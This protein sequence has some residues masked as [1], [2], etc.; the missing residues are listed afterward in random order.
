MPVN[1]LY[2]LHLHVDCEKNTK[3]ND[4]DRLFDRAQ[5]IPSQLE[6]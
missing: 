1:I 3:L 6:N 5:Q 4:S 2:K